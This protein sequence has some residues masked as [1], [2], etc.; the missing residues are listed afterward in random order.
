MGIYFDG[1]SS[2]LAG[3]T[4]YVEKIEPK[5]ELICRDENK[6][7]LGIINGELRVVSDDEKEK[8]YYSKLF[9]VWLHCMADTCRMFHGT[10]MFYINI[11]RWQDRKYG[12]CYY[13]PEV[14]KDRL[15]SWREK[16]LIEG[17]IRKY[18]EAYGDKGAC[19]HFSECVA[20][21]R[22]ALK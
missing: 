15:L 3:S 7:S 10:D 19:D 4:G 20:E 22:L 5:Y 21:I 12:T 16:E 8:L 2:I 18:Q 17:F 9:R 11:L 13:V 14:F 6:S 1:M